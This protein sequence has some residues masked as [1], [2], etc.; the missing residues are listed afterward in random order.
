MPSVIEW[1]YLKS[2]YNYA[3]HQIKSEWKQIHIYGLKPAC[4]YEITS[5]IYRY[6]K[7]Y[8]NDIGIKNKY[9]GDCRKN[10]F[11]IRPVCDCGFSKCWVKVVFV[12]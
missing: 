12:Y 8:T 2:G 5:P 11:I 6:I 9:P 10:T 3:K 1:I 7:G 4:G